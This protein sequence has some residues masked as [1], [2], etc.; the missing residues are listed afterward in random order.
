M[1]PG[2]R[3]TYALPK[4]KVAVSITEVHCWDKLQSG[5]DKYADTVGIGLGG[6]WGKADGPSY[7]P[8]WIVIILRA[9]A[10]PVLR[11]PC[12]NH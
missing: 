1:N 4:D 11:T 12:G 6:E 7:F 10:V 5:T 9:A 3:P 8:H 2:S